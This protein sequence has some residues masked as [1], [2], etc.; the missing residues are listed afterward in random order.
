MR[1]QTQRKITNALSL[2]PFTFLLLFRN[3][4]SD[5][6]YN[7]ERIGIGS[8]GWRYGV[9]W[10]ALLFL[11]IGQKKTR[12][13]EIAIEHHNMITNHTFCHLVFT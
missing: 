12:R 5:H 13:V 2:F 4:Q 1:A 11:D 7:D 9:G 3:W 10:P 6:F 8:L